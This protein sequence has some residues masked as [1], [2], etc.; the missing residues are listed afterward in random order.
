VCLLKDNSGQTSWH[1]AALSGQVTVLEKLW[2][3]AKE[4]Q[5]NPEKFRID[6]CLLKDKSGQT[7]WHKAAL[8]SDVDVLKKLRDWAKELYQKPVDLGNEVFFL[9]RQIWTVDLAHGSKRWQVYGIR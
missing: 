1:K 7:T 6:V 3:L 8:R 4:L 2:D 9:K 5:L